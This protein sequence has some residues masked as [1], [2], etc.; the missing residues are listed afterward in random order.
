[1]RGIGSARAV[2][3]QALWALTNFAV[4]VL[5]ARG[6]D[7]AEFGLF[8]IAYSVL[9]ISAGLSNA[10]AG[11]VLAVTR[12]M[13]IRR[14]RT[15]VENLEAISGTK[16][17]A[18]GVVCIFAVS[19]PI[20]VAA[21]ALLYAP[22]DGVQRSIWVIVAFSPIV[23]LAEGIRSIFYALRRVNEAL[24]MSL[25]WVIMQTT[26]V[27]GLWMTGGLTPQGAAFAWSLG[28][29]AAVVASMWTHPL[30]PAF[31][32]VPREEWHR[33]R[34]FGMEYIATAV[35]AQ[36]LVFI[37]GAML[38]L[39]GAAV[40]RAMQSLFGPLNVVLAGI[41][42][43]VVPV[44]SQEPG[45]ARRAGVVVAALSVAATTALTIVFAAFPNLGTVFL[46]ASWPRD[47]LL[48][49]GFGLG[50]CAV[51]VVLGALIIFRAWDQ[52]NWSSRL[53]V[54]SALS[55]LA[56]FAAGALVDLN[57]AVWASSIASLSVAS[58]WWWVA[59]NVRPQC[60]D[61]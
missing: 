28:G 14:G 32:G 41:R 24:L 37:A 44:V 57:W 8:G 25:T 58:L 1:M 18:M 30:I 51:G 56:P 10:L 42:N 33:R 13:T 52:G 12:G 3:D 55:V 17:R 20:L 26:V 38:G 43:A 7:T 9:I 34:Q 15:S 23:V 60:G 22:S 5:V 11:E 39:S 4:V 16:R 61:R 46:G 49:V 53:R 36:A 2:G 50:R 35:P 47:S 19:V 27:G 59:H 40:V 45:G 54:V 31:G 6:A 48:V 29:L 21:V